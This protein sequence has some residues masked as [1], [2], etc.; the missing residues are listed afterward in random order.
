MILNSAAA[1]AY[2]ILLLIIPATL[3]SWHGLAPDLSA[4]LIGRYFATA[5]LGMGLLTWFARHADESQARDA[6][7]LSLFIANIA[8]LVLSLYATLTAQM[9][10]LGWLAVIL[11]LLL[12]I[13][14]GY[15]QFRR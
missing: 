14:F 8:G 3:L 13:G 6:I 15:F 10:S 1:F 11:Y 7:V 5:L 12:S 9:S 2:C 4:Q